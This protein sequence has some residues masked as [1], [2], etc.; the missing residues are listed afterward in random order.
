MMDM[1]GYLLGRWLQFCDWLMGH[2][3]DAIE[4]FA[5]A[6]FIW[7]YAAL[8]LSLWRWWWSK[9]RHKIAF[10]LMLMLIAHLPALPLVALAVALRKR[11]PLL[12]GTRRG[13]CR[14]RSAVA[15]RL[16]RIK[17]PYGQAWEWR[18]I[19][20]ISIGER[21]AYGHRVWQGDAGDCESH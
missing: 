14:F 8:A 6:L 3:V 9:R 12:E 4:A 10:G 11:E 1:I 5:L 17:H 18:K 15:A 13:M 2:K 16:L 19:N 20:G 21:K 7:P